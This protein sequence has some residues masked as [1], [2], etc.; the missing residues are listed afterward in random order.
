MNKQ[1]IILLTAI[2]I[3]CSAC[4]DFLAVDPTNERALRGYEDV[5]SMFSRYMY[6]QY[7][8]VL[9]NHNLTNANKRHFTSDM[10]L[11][12]EAYADNIDAEFSWSIYTDRWNNTVPNNRE[13]VYA[14][15]F[16]YNNFSVPE[17]IW[18]EYYRQVGFFNTYID[19]MEDFDDC[20][21]QQRHQLVG[22]IKMHRAYYLFKLYQYF[23]QY[24]SEK[25]GIPIY[26]YTG[27]E[28]VGVELPRKSHTEVYEILLDDLLSV[29]EMLDETEP[30]N[31]FNVLYNQ[32]SLNNLLA[33]VYWFKAE[34]PAQESNDYQLLK[35][36]ATVAAEGIN[37]I[38]ATSASDYLKTKQGAHSPYPD[39]MLIAANSNQAIS[40]IFGPRSGR[41]TGMRFVEEFCFFPVPD[42]R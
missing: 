16:L 26:L 24:N 31:S 8:M 3:T 19:A 1:Y 6:D 12:F 32:R 34:S 28:V 41:P 17:Q 37:G 21:E 39:K 27:D 18:N 38:T 11:M 13:I 22:E 35:E 40:P 20:T 25:D 10:L 42:H 23:S 33:Q 4:S 14:N 9:P 36:V 29:K 30:K 2:I 7:E 15:W 5:K